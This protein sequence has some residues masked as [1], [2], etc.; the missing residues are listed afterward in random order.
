MPAL[1]HLCWICSYVE[2]SWQMGS[3][4]AGLE[5]LLL[6]C[7]GSP[8][9][10][11]S[12]SKKLTW[13]WSPGNSRSPSKSTESPE[14]FFKALLKSCLQISCW[15]SH[16][17]AW[18]QNGRNLQKLKQQWMDSEMVLIWARD[19]IGLSWLSRPILEV[20]LTRKSFLELFHAS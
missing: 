9:R 13:D 5:G 1:T 16:G 15:N 7:T 14:G 2:V 4:L 11:R 18:S 20:F 10:D 3:E 6:A 12:A 17:K 8:P 19:T